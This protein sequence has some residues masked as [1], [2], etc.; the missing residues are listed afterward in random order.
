MREISEFVR[1]VGITFLRHAPLYG[2]S[3]LGLGLALMSFALYD[4]ASGNPFPV[5]EILYA[6]LLALLAWA[7]GAIWDAHPGAR[8]REELSRYLVAIKSGSVR[9][10]A[11]PEPSLARSAFGEEMF[12]TLATCDAAWRRDAAQT[13]ERFLFFLAFSTR[14]AHEMKTPLFSLRLLVEEM[15]RLFRDRSVE[16]LA[17]WQELRRSL[18]VEIRRVEDLVDLLLGS[19]RLEDPAQDYAPEVV[20]LVDFVRELIDARR[21]EWILR[22]I[23]PRIEGED[24]AKDLVVFVDRKWFRLL[25][26][27]ILRNAL[28]YG[29]KDG[30]AT[31]TFV[32]RVVRGEDKIRLIFA[33]EGP[34]I[35]PEDVPRVFEPFFTGTHGRKNSQA[36]GIGLYLAREA[37]LRM[38]AHL[39]V[40]ST[41][42]EGTTLVFELPEAMYYGPWRLGYDAGRRG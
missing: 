7:F 41:W 16:D 38:G 35:P 19:V 17:R 21:E 6:F 8:D 2:L 42:G 25:L 23:Y 36:T 28:R 10:H 1:V 27:Q 32:V 39:E 13:R 15:E 34:G 31:A 9:E 29:K 33:D 26:E 11:P 5:R 3:L 40:R 20:P 30:A 22:R 4:L 24:S 37:A 14:F 18:S 12:A